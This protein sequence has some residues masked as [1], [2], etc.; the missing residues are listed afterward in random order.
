LKAILEQEKVFLTASKEEKETWS[1]KRI[2][3]GGVLTK[4]GKRRLTGKGKFKRPQKKGDFSKRE[5]GSYISQ[6][7]KRE[8]VCFPNLELLGGETVASDGELRPLGR[9]LTFLERGDVLIIPGRKKEEVLLLRGE[10]GLVRRNSIK[11]RGGERRVIQHLSTAEENSHLRCS[12]LRGSCKGYFEFVGRKKKSLPPSI[13]GEKK[14]GT[15]RSAKKGE[16][17]SLLISILLR[18]QKLR[19]D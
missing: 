5:K 1:G 2:L 16:G 15:D 19:H 6:S 9:D 7:G 18:R 12:H 11:K 14:K 17:E 3:R 4:K 10:G 8:R 13:C